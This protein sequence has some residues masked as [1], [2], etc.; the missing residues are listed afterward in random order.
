MT[1]ASLTNTFVAQAQLA[2]HRPNVALSSATTAYDLCLQDPKAASSTQPISTLIL[3]CKREK[4]NIRE[5]ERLR[6]RNALLGE[7][8]EL[9]TTAKKAETMV[10]DERLERHEIGRTTA[11]EEKAEAAV[12]VKR[13]IDELR[14]IFA[15]A[16]PQNVEQRVGNN[17]ITYNLVTYSDQEIPDY[18]LDD[19]T[20]EIMHDRKIAS[21]VSI[22]IMLT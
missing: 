14:S 19:I 8:E 18:L 10:I 7:L 21:I 9:L 12:I 16:D 15:I 1:E 22:H 11:S 2:M 4:W 20:F 17:P 6:A 5:K 3:K 13:K